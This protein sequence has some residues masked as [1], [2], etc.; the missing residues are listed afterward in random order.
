MLHP[1]RRVG[2]VVALCVAM[3]PLATPAAWSSA[4][5][6]ALQV[7]ATSFDPADFPASPRIDNSL[8]PWTPG[9]KLV[10]DG[11]VVEDGVTSAH[12]VVVVVTDLVKVVDGVSALIVLERDFSD[13]TPE[14]SELSLQA[15]DR[16][17]T[18]W[19][20][21][22]YPEQFEDGKFV[23]APNTWL[24]GVNRAR[25]GILMQAMPKV[26]GF[27]Y[28]QGIAPEV[29]FADRAEVIDSGRRLCVP[30]GCYHDVWVVD[31]WDALDPDGGHQ[32]KYHAPGAGVVHIQ[33]QGGDAQETLSLVSVSR[34]NDAALA[35]VRG[36]ALR[37]DRRAYAHAQD[38]YAGSTPAHKLP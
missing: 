27:S 21:G 29:D 34:L 32:I 35:D 11:K 1:V 25:A 4:K 3:V 12:R 14:E 28:S 37:L 18:V 20:L 5:P 8:L 2:F 13:G 19:N 23:G 38:V 31:E 30:A 6:A 7:P 26:G 33:A 15:Q 10:Y 16:N 9:T 36:D 24:A 17:G 22:E